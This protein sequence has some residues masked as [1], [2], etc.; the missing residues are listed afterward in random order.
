MFVS[1]VEKSRQ[2]GPQLSSSVEP[3]VRHSEIKRQP[4][5]YNI[6]VFE[7]HVVALDIQRAAQVEPRRRQSSSV[8]L[9]GQRSASKRVKHEQSYSTTAGNASKVMLRQMEAS[10]QLLEIKLTQLEDE[11]KRR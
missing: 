11:W 1:T 4:D 6:L 2:Q 9:A 3:E 7:S 5:Q 10:S 8:A